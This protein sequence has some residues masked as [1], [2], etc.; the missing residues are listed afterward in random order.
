MILATLMLATPIINDNN[1]G[2]D[3]SANWDR[4]K[5]VAREVREKFSND[6]SSINAFEVA[7]SEGI[8][9]K[10]FKPKEGDKIAEASGL[11]NTDGKTIYLN[12]TDSPERQ[13]FTLAHELGHYF[14]KH[15]PDQYGVYWRNQQYA[16]GEKTDA[17]KEADCFASELLM[18]KS[19]I[20]KY[21]KKYHFD[22]TD[23]YALAN[24]LGVSSEAMKYRLRDIRNGRVTQ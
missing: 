9:I 8:A 20:E 24:L 7:K 14:L 12:I 22:D 19:L 3:M 11:L 21:K 10:Y 15:S 2:Q 5:Q 23:Y 17:E 13:N 18:P 4:A 6:G 16:V 1:G